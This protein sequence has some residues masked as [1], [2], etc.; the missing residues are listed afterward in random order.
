M[1]FI[2]ISIRYPICKIPARRFGFVCER[3]KIGLLL[4]LIPGLLEPERKSILQRLTLP[5]AV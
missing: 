5:I 1:P 2:E 4:C 3:H